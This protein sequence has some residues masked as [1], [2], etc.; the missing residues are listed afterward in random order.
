MKGYRHGLILALIMG[1]SISLLP[2]CRE[3]SAP[4]KPGLSISDGNT[5]DIVVVGSELEGVYLAK[6]AAE[7]GASVAIIDPRRE[8]GGQLIQ[9]EMTFLD[10]PQDESGKSLLQGEVKKLFS[11]YKSGKIRKISEFREYYQSLLAGFPV[12]SGI[13]LGEVE[14]VQEDARKRI[15]SL[16]YTTND[17]RKK[18]VKA[19]YFVDNTDFAALAGKLNVARIPGIESVFGGERDHMAATMM[20]KF[21]KVD[22]DAFKKEVQGLSLQEREAKY[23]ATTTVTDSYTW[24][25]GNV[26]GSY[27]PGSKQAFLRGLN[28][29][30]QRDGDVAVNALLLF[31]VDPSSE[32]SIQQAL[33]LGRKE[34]DSIVEHLRKQLPGWEEVEVNGYPSYLYI[35]DYDRY[36]TEY[37]L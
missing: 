24:G 5:Y 34:T 37:V 32:Q 22:W 4:A 15:Q 26:G 11:G 33:E 6:A 27:K 35:R 17:G 30:N 14:V 19:K 28:T 9:G 23:G 12:E 8:A 21:R 25:F 29:I 1:V 10:E 20:M 3:K 13:R 36:E 16:F 7:E 2:A 18:T 31:N